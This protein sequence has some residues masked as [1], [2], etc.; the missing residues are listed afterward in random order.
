MCIVLHQFAKLMTTTL[1]LRCRTVQNLAKMKWGSTCRRDPPPS[2]MCK[3][4]HPLSGPLLIFCVTP[5]YSGAKL[6]KIRK[7]EMGS[8]CRVRIFISNL[9]RATLFIFIQLQHKLFILRYT[10][11]FESD[12]RRIF[13]LF[14]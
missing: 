9:L 6:R 7:N 11:L 5:S 4:R 13:F 2:I 12:G 14:S 3:H 1:L 8:L 10:S